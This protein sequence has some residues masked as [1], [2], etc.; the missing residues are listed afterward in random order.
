MRFGEY[1]KLNGKLE[2]EIYFQKDGIKINHQLFEY[3][4][5]NDF[6]IEFSDK[7]YVFEGSFSPEK[8][9]DI[10][11]N[12]ENAQKSLEDAFCQRQ[13]NFLNNIE[14][15]RVMLIKKFESKE[16]AEDFLKKIKETEKCKDVYEYYS[17]T[18]INIFDFFRK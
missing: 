1:E 18:E 9:F 7:Q 17:K 16:V 10:K 12:E 2:G 8:N 5:I 15:H 3:N 14:I 6:N 13:M 11:I 4:Q